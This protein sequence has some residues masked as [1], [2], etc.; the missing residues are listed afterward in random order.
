[1]NGKVWGAWGLVLAMLAAVVLSERPTGTFVGRVVDDA[2]NPL[3]GASVTL[4]GPLRRVLRTGRDGRCRGERLPV[5]SYDVHVSSRGRVDRWI[6]PPAYIEEQKPFRLPDVAL[7]PRAP[8]VALSS[9][10]RVFTAGEPVRLAA[11]AVAIAQMDFTL[12]RLEGSR[13]IPLGSWTR[14]FVEQAEDVEGWGIRSIRVPGLLESGRYSVTVTAKPLPDGIRPVRPLRD[15]HVF[16]VTKLALVAK[17]DSRQLLVMATDMTT[18]LPMPGV[19]LAAVGVQQ[20]SGAPRKGTQRPLGTTDAE[21]LW[22]ASASPV[23]ALLVQG[24]RGADLA[25]AILAEPEVETGTFR[26][27]TWSD[28]PLYRPGHVVGWK[29]AIRRQ[30][31]PDRRRWEAPEGTRLLATLESPA[32]R[33]VD[34]QTLTVDAWGTVAGS[35]R[36]PAAAE[37]GPWQIRI[38]EADRPDRQVDVHGFRVAAYRKPEAKVVLR[39]S[40]PRQAGPGPLVM[41]V[42]ARDMTGGILAEI[43]F[44]WRAWSESLQAPAAVAGPSWFHGMSSGWSHEGSR[45]MLRAEGE[46]RTDSEGRAIV[47]V[48]ADGPFEDEAWTFEAEIVDPSR[49]TVK[50]SGHLERVQGSVAVTVTTPGVIRN[51]QPWSVDLGLR[52]WDGKPCLSRVSGEVVVERVEWVRQGPETRE[53]RTLERTI[54]LQIEGSPDFRIDLP[55]LRQAGDVEVRA[56]LTDPDGN[57]IRSSGWAWIVGGG[58]TAAS[59]ATDGPIEVRVR[60]PFV[61]PGATTSVLIRLPDA[62]LSPLVTIEGRHIH[63]VRR[64]PAGRLE[65]EWVIE[66]RPEW[67]PN[68][69]VR[70]TGVL[71]TVGRDDLAYLNLVPKGAELGVRLTPRS[72]TVLPGAMA[73][74]EVRTLD[75][76]GRPTAADVALAVVDQAVLDL[77][78]DRTPDPRPAFFGPRWDAV[79]TALSFS[80]SFT[81]GPPKDLL[82]PETRSRFEDT[83][84]W[85][86]RIRTD[87]SGKAIVRFRMP[88]DL[89]T[90][91][92]TALGLTRSAAG[93]LGRGQLLTRKPLVARLGLPAFLVAGDRLEI[94]GTLLPTIGGE[95]TVTPW[96]RGRGVTL[97]GEQDGPRTAEAGR[98]V[99]VPMRLEVPAT[100]S[101]TPAA[102][103]EIA[104]GGRGKG[105]TDGL[106][107]TLPILAAHPAETSVVR[108]RLVPGRAWTWKPSEPDQHLLAVAV[109]VPDPASVLPAALRRLSEEP[110]VCSE[111]MAGVMLGKA[112]SGDSA[113]AGDILATLMARQ[114]PDGGWGW[115]PDDESDPEVT[116]IVLTTLADVRALRLPM[117][118]E[119]IVRG[120]DWLQGKGRKQ[121]G[122]WQVRGGIVLGAGPDGRAMVAATL[123]RWGDRLPGWQPGEAGLTDDGRAW[124]L[125]ALRPGH[126][127]AEALLRTVLQKAQTTG[128]QAYW[129]APMRESLGAYLEVPTTAR[130]VRALARHLPDHPLVQAGLGALLAEV[131]A[132]GEQGWT[133]TLETAETIRTLRDLHP[134]TGQAAGAHVRFSASGSRTAPMDL[135]S[136]DFTAVAIR[137]GQSASL[138]ASTSVPVPVRL[139]VSRPAPDGYRQTGA[140][141]VT[142]RV[143]AVPEIMVKGLFGGLTGHLYDNQDARPDH[144]NWSRMP[145]VTAIPLRAPMATIVTLETSQTLRHVV[146]EEPLPAGTEVW[147]DPDGTVWSGTQVLDDRVV[148]MIQSLPKGKHVF[149]FYWRALLP[150]SVVHRGTRFRPFYARG[151]AVTL[152]PV[153]RVVQP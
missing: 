150:G 41:E 95:R 114:H 103:A 70:V 89:T 60:D 51:S 147:H 71:G 65:H 90:W 96:W 64:L 86:P 93:G 135:V 144:P 40:K 44:T 116:S 91:R 78:P 22:R 4:E 67:A 151:G 81:A 100:A 92:M 33:K 62:R 106:V 128:D 125:L 21:G 115:F 123:A 53:V 17:R 27:I 143:V 25:E 107:R 7:E 39:P 49:M 15:S 13:S 52:T 129:T 43:P 54:P 105:L 6:S 118:P 97:Q 119:A 80:E 139:L 1:M 50:G 101:E 98:P 99:V 45:G 79:Q 112:L 133:S 11:R 63:E 57:T 35:M 47:R 73:E 132:S 110:Y 38:A 104:F 152:A 18:G 10:E 130:T 14:P 36:L 146:L 83:A 111:Q 72:E 58:Q 61:R 127:A 66:A 153:T 87:A 56:V 28:R 29:T 84:A 122:T 117:D 138:V 74:V 134:A 46:G 31:E 109:G 26:A 149:R 148:L 102:S 48:D 37:P 88:E 142:R 145:D 131:G 140:P 19:S 85:L 16:T 82:P 69:A 113:G 120:L 20:E 126:P 32:G 77:E 76:E 8:E 3:A 23:G 2:G 5:G 94:V 121:D 141:V 42:E 75:D 68:V 108:A 55:P 9:P 24:Q 124:S 59:D 136:A 34:Q 30:A 12:N 137:P